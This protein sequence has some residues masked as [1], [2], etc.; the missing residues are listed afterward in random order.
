MKLR[1][2]KKEYSLDSNLFEA[3]FT[4]LSTLGGC[5]Y[6]YMHIPKDLPLNLLNYF[7][8]V[9]LLGFVFG[10]LTSSFLVWIYQE[11]QKKIKRK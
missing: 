10:F 3:V 5:I 9:C 2:F 11:L 6:G 7:A 8:M 4:L 1:L